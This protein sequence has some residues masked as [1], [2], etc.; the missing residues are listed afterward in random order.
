MECGQYVSSWIA[1]KLA[2]YWYFRPS[3][4][5]A[6]EK[7]NYMTMYNLK[8]ITFAAIVSNLLFVVAHGLKA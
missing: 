8:F 2:T 5:V 6:K 7:A 1:H 3:F 4:V